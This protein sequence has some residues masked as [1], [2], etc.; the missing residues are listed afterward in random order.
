MDV[1]GGFFQKADHARLHKLFVF[2]RFVASDADHYRA[3]PDGTHEIK[4]SKFSE[5]L[6][7]GFEEFI[8]YAVCKLKNEFAL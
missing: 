2:V 5:R 3:V 4:S 1:M 7:D 6:G 8:D